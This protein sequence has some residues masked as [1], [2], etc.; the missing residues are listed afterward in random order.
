MS[1]YEGPVYQ[2]T[3][4]SSIKQRRF[5][6]L[7]TQQQR[8]W[9]KAKDTKATQE[10]MAYQLPHKKGYT[11]EQKKFAYEQSTK[12]VD[13]TQQSNEVRQ[14]SYQLP[15]Q[16]VN[17]PYRFLN[18]MDQVEEIDESVSPTPSYQP[19]INNVSV[20]LA[21]K[22]DDSELICTDNTAMDCLSEKS[23]PNNLIRTVSTRLVKDKASFLLFE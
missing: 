3:Q 2:K 1:E 23:L 7:S 6:H 19:A 20:N 8:P 16:A 13:L 21:K 14:K 10:N 18:D 4:Q 12:L 15:K 9:T 17:Q 11:N 22:G 5:N